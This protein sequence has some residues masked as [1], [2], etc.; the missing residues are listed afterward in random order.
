MVSYIISG[1]TQ[2][3]MH[4]LSLADILSNL[5]VMV[6][7][8]DF[9]QDCQ[10]RQVDPEDEL[11]LWLAMLDVPVE[12]MSLPQYVKSFERYKR[13]MHLLIEKM[14]KYGFSSLAVITGNT[15]TSNP[16]QT[17]CY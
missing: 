5:D 14:Q 10:D 11:D 9:L 4:D 16:T 7:L 3:L 15:E 12:E 17:S 2:V 6:S 8:D 13:Q 1:T